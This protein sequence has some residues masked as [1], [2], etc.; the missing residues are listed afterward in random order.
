LQFDQEEERTGL[1]IVLTHLAGI[2]QKKKLPRYGRLGGRG[3]I[4]ACP[5]FR[6]RRRTPTSKANS[7]NGFWHAGE[8]IMQ[9]DR[10]A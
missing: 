6:R 8:I 7:A 9:G 1:P 10:G 3:P 2:G 5:L 4:P